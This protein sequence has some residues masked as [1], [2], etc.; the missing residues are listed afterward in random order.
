MHGEG[1]RHGLMM[2]PCAILCRKEVVG[3]QALDCTLA[4]EMWVEVKSTA[5]VRPL[6][7]RNKREPA[8]SRCP[9]AAFPLW[10]I[11][12]SASVSGRSVGGP[13]ELVVY[14]FISRPTLRSRTIEHGRLEEIKRP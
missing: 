1:L 14:N 6:F 2:K 5:H 10:E 4:G 9:P 13:C 11:D 8:C 3:F 12:A 7:C